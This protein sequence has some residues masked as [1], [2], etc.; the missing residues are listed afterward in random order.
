MTTE[1][2]VTVSLP[3]LL[4]PPLHPPDPELPLKNGLFC[5]P[6]MSAYMAEISPVSTM[7][8]MYSDALRYCGEAI[9][10]GSPRATPLSE[11]VVILLG[12]D[13]LDH[14][15]L[16]EVLVDLVRAFVGAPWGVD[17][18]QLK[19]LAKGRPRDRNSTSWGGTAVRNRV[20][21]APR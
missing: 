3:L 12:D 5:T 17:A 11:R 1:C 7:N 10:P 2:V 15:A 6:C 20:G 21:G 14:L 18:Q 19:E 16:P 4:P 13:G 8:A 9:R